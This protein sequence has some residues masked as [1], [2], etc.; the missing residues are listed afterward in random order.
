MQQ[1]PVADDLADIGPAVQWVGNLVTQV[2]LPPEVRYA[3]EVCVEE[4]LANLVKHGRPAG[5]DKD[6]AIGFSLIDG[7][8]TVVINDCC[9]PFDPVAT[10]AA[11]PPTADEQRI[12]GH[13]LRLLRAFSTDMAYQTADGRNAL[14]LVFAAPE[15]QVSLASA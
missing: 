4:A 13:G 12:G 2:C 14:T 8:A 6:L 1:R 5:R 11:D 7:V 3:V 15:A 9:L 10:P